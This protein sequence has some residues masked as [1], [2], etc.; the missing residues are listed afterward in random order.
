MSRIVIMS[1]TVI[2]G[3]L[4][5]VC[6][7]DTLYIIAIPLESRMS[8]AVGCGIGRIVIAHCNDDIIRIGVR[9]DVSLQIAV[10]YLKTRSIRS[11]QLV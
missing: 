2:R 11:I 8:A 1:H 5:G 10:I 6:F 9:P 4:F 7:Y 3:F